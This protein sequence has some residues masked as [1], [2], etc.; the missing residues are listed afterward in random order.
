MFENHIIDLN[1]FRHVRE[2]HQIVLSGLKEYLSLRSILSIRSILSLRSSLSSNLGLDSFESCFDKD[3]ISP[4]VQLSVLI[5]K[6]VLKIC[7]DDIPPNMAK[8]IR[9]DKKLSKRSIVHSTKAREETE[10][11]NSLARNRQAG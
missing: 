8:D 10:K 2:F 6:Y 1:K 4:Q 11:Q 3:G 9:P 7:I 5:L